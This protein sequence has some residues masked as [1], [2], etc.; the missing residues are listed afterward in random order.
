LG[1]GVWKEVVVALKT[2]RGLEVWQVS[3]KL[4]EEVYR[5]TRRLPEE[6]KF[7][8][9]SQMRRAAVSIPTN[10]AEGYGRSHRGD[11]LHHLSLPRA[12]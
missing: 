12:R 2:Y 4:V 1:V 8:L 11:Y 6:E 7:G 9:V 3:L 10:I 5:V